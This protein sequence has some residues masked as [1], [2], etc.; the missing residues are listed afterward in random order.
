MGQTLLCV[1][2]DGAVYWED[3]FAPVGQWLH[4]EPTNENDHARCPDGELGYPAPLVGAIESV[5]S[6]P[7]IAGRRLRERAR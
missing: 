7:S 1:R 5:Q 4:A 2:C 3:R 6:G